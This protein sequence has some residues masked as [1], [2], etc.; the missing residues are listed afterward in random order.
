M[1]MG[2]VLI[3]RILGKSVVPSLISSGSSLLYRKHSRPL[4]GWLVSMYH[5]SRHLLGFASID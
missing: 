5:P 2:S 1:N 3:G 4:G